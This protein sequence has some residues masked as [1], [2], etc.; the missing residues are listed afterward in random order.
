MLCGFSLPL[1]LHAKACSFKAIDFLSP[2][3]LPLRTS[4]PLPCLVRSIS[5]GVPPH[6]RAVMYLKRRP[7]CI[8]CKLLQPHPLGFTALGAWV[9]RGCGFCFVGV[10]SQTRQV[11]RLSFCR[12]VPTTYDIPQEGCLH[13]SSCPCAGGKAFCGDRRNF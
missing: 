7:L 13:A 4:Q 12:C 11:R 8:T 3:S 9:I 6:R 2:L 1:K 10:L 5:G